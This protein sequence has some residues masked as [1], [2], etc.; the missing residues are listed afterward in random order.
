MKNCSVSEWSRRIPPGRPDPSGEPL[1]R[2]ASQGSPRLASG[3]TRRSL[4]RRLMK[5]E[6]GNR[7]S[8]AE[9][10]FTLKRET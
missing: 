3:L 8:A 2:G 10:N 5:R 1:A 7:T 4:G 9:A 6:Y